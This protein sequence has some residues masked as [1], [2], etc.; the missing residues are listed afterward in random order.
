MTFSVDRSTVG[1]T[2]TPTVHARLVDKSTGNE[3][4]TLDM[5]AGSSY[6][7][8]TLVNENPTY[9]PQ[10]DYTTSYASQI[11]GTWTNNR[12]AGPTAS[13]KNKHHI[14]QVTKTIQNLMFKPISQRQR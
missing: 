2:N 13:D 10:F 1:T 7:F 11:L 9:T 4:E 8:N 5:T 3:V 12:D 6:K 14:L